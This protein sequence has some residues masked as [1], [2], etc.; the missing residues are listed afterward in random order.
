[1]PLLCP[2]T[3]NIGTLNDMIRKDTKVWQILNVAHKVF[4]FVTQVPHI[5]VELLETS[6]IA[7]DKV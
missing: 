4:C 6:L 3:Y 2:Q 1:M 7:V 5:G